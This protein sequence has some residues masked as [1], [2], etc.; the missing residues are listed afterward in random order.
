MRSR[1]GVGVL[2]VEASGALVG[3]RVNPHP[4]IDVHGYIETGTGWGP[5]SST[6]TLTVSIQAENHLPETGRVV[7]AN[8]QILRVPGDSVRS[9]DS[10]GLCQREDQVRLCGRCER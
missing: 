7:H 5:L 3:Q 9:I 1:L 2:R 6:D 4:M 10:L 8:S